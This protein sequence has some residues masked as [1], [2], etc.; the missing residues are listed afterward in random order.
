DVQC[1]DLDAVR[2][3][4]I[5]DNHKAMSASEYGNPFENNPVCNNLS[6]V[7]LGAAEIDLDYNVN[8]TTDSL[9]NLIGGSGGHAD[10]AYGSELTIIISPLIKARIPLIK[11]N[12]MTVTTPGCD[13]DILVTE[14]G[15][16]V[17]PLRLDLLEKLT[18]SS[19]PIF[20]IKE[21][22][23]LSHKITGVPKE[24]KGSKEIIGLVEYRDGSCIDCLYKSEYI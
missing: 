12:V 15:I 19:F 21:L 10:I 5:N 24:I 14:R 16:A 22:Y 4:H 7:I 13:I 18:N 6:F 17:N 11:Q 23:D 8:V 9:G 2:S 20:T 3:Y 1:F